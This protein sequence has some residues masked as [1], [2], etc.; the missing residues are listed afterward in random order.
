VWVKVDDKFPEHPKVLAAGARL[1]RCGCGRVIAI[2]QAS[3]CYANRNETDGVIPLEILRSAFRLYD[4]A[5]LQVAAAMAEPVLIG[6]ETKSGLLVALAD[7]SGYQL[8]DYQDYQ[9]TRAEREDERDWNRRRIALYRNHDLL[10]EIRHR[11]GDCCRY[12]GSRVDWKDRRGPTGATYDHVQPRGPDIAENIVVACRRCNT[13]KGQ[14]SVAQA[15]MRLRPASVSSSEL[16]TDQVVLRPPD[17]DPDPIPESTHTPRARG[18]LDT[19]GVMAG[20]L[21]RDH[22]RHAWCGRICVPDFLHDQF[23]RALGAEEDTADTRLRGRGTRQERGWYAETLTSL[24]ET[25]PIEP[26]PVKF[27]RARF[28]A[29]FPTSAPRRARGRGT[30]LTG[31]AGAEVYDQVMLGTA[32]PGGQ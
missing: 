19:G 25:E 20:T 26:D 10:Q 24:T 9:P 21:P 22:L 3:A 32:K 8:H 6:T 12:C 18:R 29:A 27:W 31:S 16:D 23:R 4:H 13:A 2:W 11:D 28:A 1:G 17:P 5:P 15:G 14:Q 30:G 7:G